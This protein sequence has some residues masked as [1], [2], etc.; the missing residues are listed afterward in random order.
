MRS[1]GHFALE[2]VSSSASNSNCTSPVKEQ[3]RLG[4][5]EYRYSRQ[6]DAQGRKSSPAVDIIT[7]TGYPIFSKMQLRQWRVHVRNS[8]TQLRENRDFSTTEWEEDA[9]D[10]GVKRGG[11]MVFVV[12]RS[13]FV[14][15]KRR[16]S[17][18]S[19]NQH[20]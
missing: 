18:P 6:R 5:A 8:P 13:L 2:T 14:H 3:R 4:K 20:F 19:T 16:C 12:S 7:L 17:D 1:R 9:V 11:I 10:D 15:G